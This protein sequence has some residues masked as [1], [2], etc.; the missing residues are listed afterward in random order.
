MRDD[1]QSVVVRIH[2][3]AIPFAVACLFAALAPSLACN[4]D[5]N[6]QRWFAK[7]ES[8]SDAVDLALEGKTADERRRGTAALADSRDAGADWALKAFD[9]IARTD[10]DAMVRVAAIRGLSRTADARCIPTLVKLLDSADAEA[11][12]VRKAPPVVRWDAAKLLLQVVDRYHYEEAQR[13]EIVRC[14]LDRAAKEADRNVR[15]T[16]IDTLA[17]FAENRIPPVLVDCLEAEDFAVRHAA[18][19]SLI[20]LT[21]ATH[22]HDAD[23]WRS[24]LAAHPDPFAEAGKTPPEIA[25]Q[26]P[27]K[28]ALWPW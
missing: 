23:A 11:N 2:S 1:A 3:R 10:V 9:A 18:E 7:R 20:T 19:R 4:S 17:Y 16:C 8:G 14:L 13:P 28:K 22:N 15:M 27:A 21:G 6:D 12:D 24:W 26:K 5:N 25:Q